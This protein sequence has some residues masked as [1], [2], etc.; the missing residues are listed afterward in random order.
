MKTVTDDEASAKI[1]FFKFGWKKKKHFER[2]V[3]ELINFFSLE[4]FKI[5]GD[6]IHFIPLNL[7]IQYSS[8]NLNQLIENPG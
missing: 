3:I 8:S 7:P 2:Q 6:Y 1:G 4:Y 5:I